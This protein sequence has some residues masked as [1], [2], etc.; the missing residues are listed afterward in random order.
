M[1]D[2]LVNHIQYKYKQQDAVICIYQTEK[3]S[4]NDL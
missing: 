3:S 4:L 2:K 1:Q